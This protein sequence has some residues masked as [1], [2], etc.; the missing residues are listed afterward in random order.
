MGTRA[1]KNQCRGTI[2]GVLSRGMSLSRA[3][4]GRRDTPARAMTTPDQASR[5]DQ[6]LGRRRRNR[7]PSPPSGV[8]QEQRH[9]EHE[10]QAPPPW[11]ERAG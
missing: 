5:V 1:Y 9:R 2:T 3:A 6:H 7:V 11:S 10:E 8:G 4:W